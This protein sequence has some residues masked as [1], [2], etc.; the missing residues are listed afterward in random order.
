LLLVFRHGLRVS[1]A[2]RM[3]FD[4]VDS[5]SGVLQ[6]PTGARGCL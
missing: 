6:Q 1:D 2:R 5:E 3:K 4:E